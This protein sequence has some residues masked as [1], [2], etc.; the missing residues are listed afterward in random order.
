LLSDRTVVVAYSGCE[1]RILDACRL[2]GAY[3]FQKTTLARDTIEIRDADE[4]YAKIPLGAVGLEGELSRS[5][6]LAVKTTVAGQM[7][8]GSELAA[9]PES[10]AC[11]DATHVISALSVGAF[12]LVSGGEVAAGGK[13]DVAGAGA[14]V[15]HQSE[16]STLRSAGEPDA[17]SR[18]KTDAPNEDCNSP[19][20]VFLTPVERGEA[21]TVASSDR[22]PSEGREGH[23]GREG[24]TTEG[25][26]S[27]GGPSEGRPTEPTPEPMPTEAPKAQ[28]HMTSKEPPAD[29]SVEVA[30]ETPS[31]DERWMLL[32]SSG[33]VLCELPCTRRVGK[34]SGYKLQLDAAS[35]ED[36]VAVAVP[37]DLGYSPGRRVKAVPHPARNSGLASIVFYGGLLTATVGLVLVVV[38][39]KDSGDGLN[40]P[41]GACEQEKIYQDSAHTSEG[42]PTE[43]NGL[44]YLCMAGIGTLAVGGAATLAGGI[45]WLVYDR[46]ES[47]DITLLDSERG[48]RHEDPGVRVGIGPGFLLGTF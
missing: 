36:I 39:K 8:L 21:G 43:D 7:K 28:P 2:P 34:N 41:H 19:L 38:D 45:W 32:E 12:A 27:E 44:S 33:K 14:G 47:L 17:C 48:S 6:R 23:E 42:D 16:E 20:Q 35:K 5:G 11:K 18:T 3:R 31:A 4:L 22:P 37:D 29:L 9:L 1:M 13:V 46:P 40:A 26:P 15:K 30:F 25:R 24:R 10:G